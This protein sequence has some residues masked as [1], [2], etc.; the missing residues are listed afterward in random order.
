MKGLEVDDEVVLH[1]NH[2]YVTREDDA[3]RT[4]TAPER[5]IKRLEKVISQSN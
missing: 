1:W 3:K 4:V 5:V 2:D